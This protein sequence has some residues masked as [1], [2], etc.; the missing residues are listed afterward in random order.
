MIPESW[1]DR[2]EA[3]VESETCQLY[4]AESSIPNSGLGLFTGKTIEAFQDISFPEIVIQVVDLEENHELRRRFTENKKEPDSLINHYFWNP[5]YAAAED[6]ADDVS[7]I[8]P[9]V[10][11]LA[12]SHTG[13]IN[14]LE[15]S[16]VSG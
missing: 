2:D 10:G 5:N 1:K 15:S 3:A 6:E 13:H 16:T 4:M 8:V 11:M 14:A 12:N 9:G 7:S